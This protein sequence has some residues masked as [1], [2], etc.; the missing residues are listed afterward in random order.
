[1][2]CSGTVRAGRAWGVRRKRWKKFTVLDRLQA[3]SSRVSIA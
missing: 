2:D 3:S 1:M